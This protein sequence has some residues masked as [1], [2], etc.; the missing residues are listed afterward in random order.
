MFS[1]FY[2]FVRMIATITKKKRIKTVL[3]NKTCNILSKNKMGSGT[4]AIVAG[5]L[6]PVTAMRAAV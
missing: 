6:P 3:L 2:F 4:A 1:T 5:R